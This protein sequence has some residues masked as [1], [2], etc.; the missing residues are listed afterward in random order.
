MIGGHNGCPLGS[1]SRNPRS[2]TSL[3]TSPVGTNVP[4][5]MRGLNTLV[6]SP[7]S[8]GRF[9]RCCQSANRS[10]RARERQPS[11]VL[12]PVMNR[13]QIYVDG[14]GRALCALGMNTDGTDSSRFSGHRRR[15]ASEAI[16]CGCVLVNLVSSHSRAFLAAT[17]C[18]RFWLGGRSDLTLL[19]SDCQVC[20][21]RI[22]SGLRPPRLQPQSTE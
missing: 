9:G 17:G 2:E 13:I 7:A 8:S 6:R 19:D 10:P 14:T 15:A 22:S 1:A 16:F 12:C 3:R 5:G 18:R 20:F 11:R 4:A 21:G